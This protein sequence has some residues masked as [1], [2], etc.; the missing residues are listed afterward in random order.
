MLGFLVHNWTNEE[1]IE[2]LKNSVHLPQ[3]ADVFLTAAING[4]DVPR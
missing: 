4:S 3:Y 2:W 1:V